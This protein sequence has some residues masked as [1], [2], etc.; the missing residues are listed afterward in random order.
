[1]NKP[2][3]LFVFVSALLLTAS[4]K[5]AVEN[6]QK[7]IILEAMTTGVWYVYQ[8]TEAG[9]D[10]TAGFS[11]YDFKFE[12]N[13]IVTGTKAMVSTAGTWSANITNYSISSQFP[14]AG[15]PLQKL[16]GTWIIKDS[17]LDF[18]KAEMATP[19]GINQLQLQKKP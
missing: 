13:G 3:T 15:D 7:N 6:Q 10:L 1:M 11:G 16:N 8:Y 18:V 14:S 4:C 5:K 2:L 19:A 12:Q 9:T 17:Y